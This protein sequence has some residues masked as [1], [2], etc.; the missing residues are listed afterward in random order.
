M[1]AGCGGVA[2]ST[3]RRRSCVTQKNRRCA[4]SRS[5]SC[6]R[7]SHQ[8]V[9]IEGVFR[10]ANE[11]NRRWSY[12]TAPS[13]TP[14]RS[15]S[16]SAGP[17][18]S[19][20][21]RLRRRRGPSAPL[22][23][24]CPSS[25]CLYLAKSP[26]PWSM[27]DNHA[28]G[29]MA[30]EHL[31]E[32]GFTSFGFYGMPDIAYSHQRL[33]GY[34]DRLAE[35]GIV[36]AEFNVPACRLSTTPRWVDRRL[37][38]SH[39]ARGAGVGSLLHQLRLPGRC[40]DPARPRR[41]DRSLVLG[42]HRDRNTGWRRGSKMAGPRARRNG[43]SCQSGDRPCSVAGVRHRACARSGGPDHNG[44]PDRTSGTHRGGGRTALCARHR[45]AMT[46]IVDASANRQ[47]ETQSTA[48]AV[49]NNGFGWPHPAAMPGRP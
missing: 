10:Y 41:F 16:S 13:G 47:L 1:H 26:A 32:R 7:G 17:A 21:R 44:C 46:T 27:V 49:P 4:S 2:V 22:S 20:S 40:V 5:P 29:V 48:G 15:A 9:F 19:W 6:S 34:R 3:P 8:E 37:D 39:P 25:T 28:I 23:F 38:G 12:A 42:Q 45:R 36:P 24:T 35:Q 18:T 33:A 31:L 11:H 14:C 30:A 43:W